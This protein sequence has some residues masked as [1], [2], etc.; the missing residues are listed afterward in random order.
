M[1]DNNNIP[2]NQK[3]D[4]QNNVHS[5]CQ[6]LGHATLGAKE[7]GPDNHLEIV[8]AV[9]RIILDCLTLRYET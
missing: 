8:E 6:A 4:L 5:F 3:A 9:V 7:K 2:Y 1:K